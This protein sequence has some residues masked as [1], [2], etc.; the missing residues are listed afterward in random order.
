MFMLLYCTYVSILL[1]L[2]VWYLVRYTDYK[3]ARSL[4]A[5]CNMMWY[6]R[7][8]SLNCPCYA[9]NIYVLCD[10]IY[11]PVSRS[12]PF[13]FHN[14]LW[15]WVVAC[16]SLRLSYEQSKKITGTCVLSSHH[17]DLQFVFK[18]KCKWNT[19]HKIRYILL[20]SA[21]AV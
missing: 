2:L 9:S 13:S 11:L 18:K 8:F 6:I 5:T 21:A 12:D 16:V 10:F 17:T 14:W 15:T 20:L 19:T 3:H 7:W 4:L 1:L